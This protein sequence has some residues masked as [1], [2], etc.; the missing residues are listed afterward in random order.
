M[1][2]QDMTEAYSSRLKGLAREV[3][4]ELGIALKEGV[5]LVLNG[6]SYET[7]AEIRMARNM[8]ADLVGMSTIPEVIMANS[9]G[10]SVLGL[11][12]VTN[13]A[14]GISGIPLSHKEVIETTEK[15]AGGFRR[16][17]RGIVERL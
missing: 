2:F 14:A 17:V 7:P 1:H 6:P 15:A 5:Y 3:S 12:I 9:M 4:E 10:I 11:S 16:L 13:M 8:G